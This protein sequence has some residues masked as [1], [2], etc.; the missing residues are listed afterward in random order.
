[1]SKITSYSDSYKVI[2]NYPE[3]NI[4]QKLLRYSVPSLDLILLLT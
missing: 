3:I 1:M 4:T 2:N